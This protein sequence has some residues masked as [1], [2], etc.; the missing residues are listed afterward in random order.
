VPVIT[1]R[2]MGGTDALK[3]EGLMLGSMHMGHMGAGCQAEL[4][5]VSICM[6]WMKRGKTMHIIRPRSHKAIKAKGLRGNTWK[7]IKWV[8]R[9]NFRELGHYSG[10]RWRRIPSLRGRIGVRRSRRKSSGM[11][12]T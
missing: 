12:R 3:T 10:G 5:I 8:S 9:D 4:P 11:L 7:D 1:I 6:I 2:V